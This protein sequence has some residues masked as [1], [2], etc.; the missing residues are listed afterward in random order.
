MGG[1][2]AVPGLLLRDGSATRED[3]RKAIGTWAKANDFQLSDSGD[4]ELIA[5]NGNGFLTARK[6]FRFD[7]APKDGKLLIKPS[8]RN[9]GGAGSIESR[10]LWGAPSAQ[11]RRYREA[12][13]AELR[14]VNGTAELE[15]ITTQVPGYPL[16]MTLMMMSGFCFIVSVMAFTLIGYLL[17]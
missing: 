1:T 11:A 17:R 10:L 6:E 4:G 7:L 9:L 8:V 3:L 12:L 13:L 15:K 2:V 5:L 14:R 16:W